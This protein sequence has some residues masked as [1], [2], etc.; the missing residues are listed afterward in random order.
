[1]RYLALAT[2]YDGTLAHDGRVDAVTLTSLKRLAESGRKLILVTGRELADLE[3]VF[4]D[5]NLFD[6]VVAENGA[7]LYAPAT[8]KQR[9][10][11]EAPPAAFVSELELRGVKP[12]SVGAIIVATWHPMEN[13]VLQT[14]RDL[15]LEL[16][17]IFNK[18]AVMVL[19]AGVNKAS[20]LAA[21]LEELGLSAHNVVAVGDAENDHALLQAGQ[22]SAA[23][24]NA[25]PMLKAAADIVTQADHGAGVA[26]LIEA[27][28]KNDLADVQPKDA[29]R[30]L[31]LGVRADGTEARIPAFG[32][33][34]LIAGT[35][36]SG[37]STL[38]TSLLE[39]LMA[40]HYQCCVI[41][42]EGDYGELSNVIAFGTAER[43]PDVGEILTGLERPGESVVVNLLGVKLQD[44]PAFFASLLLRLQELR[45]HRGRPHWILVDEAH[46]LLPTNWEPAS[47]TLTQALTSMIY[48]TVHPDALAPVVRES[49]DA[50]AAL[51]EA[52]REVF[53]AMGVAVPAELP[54]LESGQAML[55]CG[56]GEPF[57]ASVPPSQSERRRHQRKYAKGELGPD[58]SFYFRGPGNR[59]NLRAQNL[60]TFLQLGEGVDEETWLHHLR[61]GDYSQWLANC[62]KDD[63][64][65]RD[66][67]AI[68]REAEAL[69][70]AA[71]RERIRAA[72]EQR[73]TLP[74]DASPL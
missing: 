40:R 29:R 61:A 38:T 37:K 13:L 46:H 42:P 32:R 1:M 6:R 44:R 57:I 48:V 33:N 65:A 49:I 18:G 69:D 68:E 19:P 60:I 41:D 62:I 72:V 64:L 28:L 2:D 36:G 73:Y 7:L 35:S 12:L 71:S 54:R 27:L 23:V 24:A 47:Q 25:V 5:L 56:V 50:V 53:A 15:G 26:E 14:I 34:L 8:R 30:T 22:V 16:Q 63:E 52:P 20:G 66:V 67:R 51:G 10:L 31:L 9:V 74:E 70:A 45:A 21:A 3:S 59:L 55:H 39:Q 17:V 58:R 11:A 43:A 4:P